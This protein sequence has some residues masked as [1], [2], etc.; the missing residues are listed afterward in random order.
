VANQITAFLERLTAAQGEYNKAKVGELSAMDSVYLDFRAEV[1]RMGQTIRAYYPDLL[2]F[3]DQA[4]NDW[5]PDPLNTN[6][7]DVPFGQRPGKAIIIRDFEQFQTN[8]DI[9]EQYLDPMYKRALEFANG[10]IFSQVNQ[11]NFNTTAQVAG[12]GLYPSYVPITTAPS[13][14]DVGSAKLAWNLFKRNKIPTNP[15]DL[16]ILYHPDCHANTL[17]DPAWGQEN[18]VSAVIAQGARNDAA[19]EGMS[20]QAFKFKR[21]H[22]VQS[23]TTT[24]ATLTGT[25]TVANGST[26]VT[27]SSTKFTTTVAPGPNTYSANPGQVGWV[28]FVGD[29]PLVS[30]PMQVNTDTSGTLLQAYQGSQ[31]S[32]V[33]FNKL[34]YTGLALHRYAMVLAVRPLELVNTGGVTSR[35]I[36]LKGIPIRVMISYPHIKAGWMLTADYGMVAKVVRPDFGVI[37]NS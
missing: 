7:V 26:T 24:S 2:P 16:S 10:A 32:G 23:P 22:D 20:N 4:A 19:E 37:L 6:Y 9:I 21:R 15:A 31:T 35:T 13:T 1:A 27:G 29:S 28:Q 33:S 36:M 17:I 25:V 18:L 8:T 11:T 34:S 14:V 12:S 3:T 30:Y 5:N